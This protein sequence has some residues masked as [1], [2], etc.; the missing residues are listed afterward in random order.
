MRSREDNRRV[1]QQFWTAEGEGRSRGSRRSGS[2]ATQS[3]S[4]SNVYDPNRA[5]SS[6]QRPPAVRPNNAHSP[7]KS[8]PGRSKARRH[9]GGSSFTS[10]LRVCSIM[11]RLILITNNPLNMTNIYIYLLHP[12]MNIHCQHSKRNTFLRLVVKW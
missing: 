4:N 7:P 1:T 10:T 6:P 11:K 12:Q 8:T 2:R 3:T 5:A 9:D